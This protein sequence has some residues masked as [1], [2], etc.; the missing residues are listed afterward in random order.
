VLSDGELPRSRGSQLEG[1]IILDLVADGID[2]EHSRIDGLGV[3]WVML[4]TT[5][6]T[7]WPLQI[8]TTW[9]A[10]AAL[11]RSVAWQWDELPSVR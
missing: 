10:L 11:A 1:E 2:S 9:P 6:S 7:T 3:T 8:L 4:P 5:P